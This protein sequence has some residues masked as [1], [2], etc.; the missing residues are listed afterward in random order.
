MGRVP[1][2]GQTTPR[3]QVQTHFSAEDESVNRP[4]PVPEAVMAILRQDKFVRDEM[5][6]E[7]LAPNGLPASWF[8]AGEVHLGGQS[9]KDLI[10]EGVGPLRGANVITYW[11]FISKGQEYLL[12]LS[13][14]THDLIVK[15]SRSSGYR[16]LES[17]RAT[18]VTVTTV[19]FRFDG[20][21]YREYSAK[22]ENIK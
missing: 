15:T 21:Q 7:N 11:V 12:A 5:E 18:A 16:N 6:N 3:H 19:S 14:P 2:E 22:T 13:V 1:A 17:L 10:V 9:A 4:V 20:K 8:S